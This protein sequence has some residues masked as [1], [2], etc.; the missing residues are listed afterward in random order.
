MFSWEPYWISS[1]GTNHVW[2]LKESEFSRDL[3]VVRSCKS[4]R[5]PIISAALFL[6]QLLS[7]CT[8]TPLFLSKVKPTMFAVDQ[9]K[10]VHLRHNNRN[11]SITEQ[12]GSE[13]LNR[14]TEDVELQDPTPV[15]RLVKIGQGCDSSVGLRRQC[16][17]NN[18]FLL[19]SRERRG[20]IRERITASSKRMTY[21]LSNVW[22]LVRSRYTC[23]WVRRATAWKNR[24]IMKWQFC[25]IRKA[26]GRWDKRFLFFVLK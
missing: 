10:F 25:S 12:W 7:L 21:K 14:L 16:R 15:F 11:I 17:C 1:Y 4:F 22:S 13:E 20:S 5:Y 24:T 19:S 18:N 2:P 9:S 26:K 6:S 3:V 23:E 8:C